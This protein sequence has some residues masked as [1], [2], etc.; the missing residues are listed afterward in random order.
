MRRWTNRRLVLGLGLLGLVSGVF[1]WGRSDVRAQGKGKMPAPAAKPGENTVAAA[2]P[3]TSAL[4]SDYSKRV[5]AYIY[6][7]IPITREDLGE[8]LIA[9]HGAD[10]LNNLIN[11]K[12]IEHECR[13]RGIEITAAEVEASL[14]E[15]LRGLNVNRKEF[16]EQ[17]L[18]Q[19]K[20]TLYE[21]KEDVIRPRLMMTQLCR[22]RVQVTD[23][24]LQ[25]AFEAYYGE[26]VEAKIILW[27]RGD[28]QLAVRVYDK[29]RGSEEGFDEEARKQANPT[30]AS[31]GGRIRP[32]G[33]HTTG[34]PTLEKL[35]FSLKPG[36]VSEILDT[37]EGPVVMKVIKRL[38]P[39]T[40]KKLADVR[41]Q[42]AKEV[43]DKK[44]QQEIPIAFQ[45]MQDKAGAKT[46]L[47]SYTSDEELMS[48][49]RAEI[50]GAA[51]RGEAAV[52]LPSDVKK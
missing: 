1:V 35:A 38:P 19:Y 16:V 4:P 51:A 3:S 50:G 36:D 6:G 14:E 12:I 7:S 26:K 37:P 25:K 18:K 15:D 44:V 28:K 48:D 5:V 17:V 11:K 21:W 8:Y 41:D 24:D 27:P 10:R 47:K 31:A 43:F 33:R 13:Q 34:N 23:E 2:T 49:I 39:D 30:L 32:I 20:K 40:S 46:F 52:P 42:L 9:R 29:V 22:G 45:E